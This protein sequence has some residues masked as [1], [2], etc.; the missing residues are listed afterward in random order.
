[1]S[2]ITTTDTLVISRKTNAK[3]IMF[4]RGSST[5]Y[6]YNYI[7]APAG[8]LICILPNGVDASSAGG[9]QF[10]VNGLHPGTSLGYSLGTSS[11]LWNAVYANTFHG[12]LKGT[13]DSATKLTTVSKTTWG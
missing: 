9:M 11:L 5:D 10:S 6:P 13:A 12:T 4:S 3:H 8:G 7:A 2:G 1:M